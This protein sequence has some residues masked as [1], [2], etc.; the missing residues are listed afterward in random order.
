MSGKSDNQISFVF[1][2]SRFLCFVALVWRMVGRFRNFVCIAI[3]A[4]FGMEWKGQP[5]SRT[6]SRRSGGQGT[7]YMFQECNAKHI[8]GVHLTF[9]HTHFKT[10]I[11]CQD[12]HSKTFTSRHTFQDYTHFK[13]RISRHAFQGVRFKTHNSRHTFHDIYIYVY[14][15]YI[16]IY[17]CVQTHVS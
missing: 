15:L 13:T 16:Y 2:F 9:Q 17:I 8:S 7:F 12:T 5:Y 14:T 10:H 6:C 1:S 3:L 4:R 11:S